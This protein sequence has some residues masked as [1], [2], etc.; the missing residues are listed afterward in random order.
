MVHLFRIFR[1][2]SKKK[3]KEK[4]IYLP[5]R[6]VARKSFSPSTGYHTQ[7]KTKIDQIGLYT[8]IT[9]RKNYI[10]V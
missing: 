9:C 4:K 3:K 8:N 10:K 6:L 2:F 5:K 1:S 7:K